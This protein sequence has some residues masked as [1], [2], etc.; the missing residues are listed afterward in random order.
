MGGQHPEMSDLE[1]V[2]VVE[3]V[4]QVKGRFSLFR[5]ETLNTREATNGRPHIYDQDMWISVA[6]DKC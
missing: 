6:K 5:G 2:R 1:T 4:Q 3:Q